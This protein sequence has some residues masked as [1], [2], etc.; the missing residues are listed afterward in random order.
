[1]K[2]NTLHSHHTLPQKAPYLPELHEFKEE[3]KVDLTIDGHAC[4]HDV[5]YKAFGWIGDKVAHDCLTGQMTAED[6]ARIA[7]QDFIKRNPEHHA[8]AGRK[9]GKAPCSQKSKDIAAK[10]CKEMGVWWTNGSINR[11]SQTKPGD[12]FYRGRLPNYKNRS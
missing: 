11:R 10:L 6:A 7:R 5:L 3:W 8:N 12:D 9:G 2:I 1:M 4:Q